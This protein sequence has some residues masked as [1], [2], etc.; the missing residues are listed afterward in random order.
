MAAKERKTLEVRSLQAWRK[1]LAANHAT[2]AEIW[3]VFFK[4]HTGMECL[5]YQD[6]LDEAL[7][8][9]WVD[10]LVKRLDNDRYARKFTPRTADSRW[11]AINRRR[12]AELKAAGRLAAPGVARAPT[13]GS[14]YP[15]RPP[16]STVPTYIEARLKAN[17]R[18]WEFFQQLAPSYRRLY[19]LWID[20]A[21][22]QETKEKR[23]REA[24]AMLAA[25]QKLGLK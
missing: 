9:G 5:S 17:S 21:K 6:A 3:L 19:V 22:R 8:F 4:R 18:A 16:K 12:Y 25:G 23:L 2:Q 14:A 20:S 10:S 13:K 24:I 11:S 1:W 7:C 15:P